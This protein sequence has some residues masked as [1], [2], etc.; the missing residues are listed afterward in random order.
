MFPSSAIPI[1]PLR[2]GAVFPGVTTPIA[3]GRRRSLL[4]AQAAVKDNG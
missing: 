2:G 1:V 3:V 4:A